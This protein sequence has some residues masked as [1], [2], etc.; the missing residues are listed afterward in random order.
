SVPCFCWI[1]GD[2]HENVRDLVGEVRH[3]VPKGFVLEWGRRMIKIQR[4]RYG[5]HWPRKFLRFRPRRS[6]LQIISEDRP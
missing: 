3:D 4:R 5:E 2:L 1:Y 6:A